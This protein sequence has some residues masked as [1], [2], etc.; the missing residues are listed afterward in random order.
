MPAKTTPRN[1]LEA[2]ARSF[3]TLAEV[4]NEFFEK[5]RFRFDQASHFARWAR[6]GGGGQ[7]DAALFVLSVWNSN[8]DWAIEENGGLSRGGD[9]GGFFDLHR[10]LGNWDD[11]HRAAFLA[12]AESP[13]WL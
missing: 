12:W 1:D 10:A 6:I 3:P 9:R 2:L 4:S 11:G 13:W 8:V 5:G 7:R